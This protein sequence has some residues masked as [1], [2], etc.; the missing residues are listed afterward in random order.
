VVSCTMVC[1]LDM[2]VS[3]II[4]SANRRSDEELVAILTE[5]G[6]WTVNGR[7]NAPLCTT[8]S[9]RHAVKRAATFTL[10]GQKVTALTRRPL[11]D[12]VVFQGQMD[13]L[14]EFVRDKDI[15]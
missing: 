8:L 4:H 5:T 3:M 2:E 1:P 9:L 12:I 13:R 15:K 7:N 6:T 14:F 10:R 11:E